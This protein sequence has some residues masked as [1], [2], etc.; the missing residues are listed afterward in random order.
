MMKSIQT[1]FIGAGA[2]A[3]CLAH[4]AATPFLFIAKS[5]STTCCTETPVWWKAID[6]IFILI[7]FAAIK[8][9]TESSTP[10]LIKL[11]LW[12]S[13]TALA[14]I[15]LN[16]HAELLYTNEYIIYIPSLLLVALHFYNLKF[17]Q[18]KENTCCSM[19]KS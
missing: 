9:S 12:V 16:E 2:S 11:S 15:I 3:L 14:L 1:D 10:K 18:C 8:K 13:W 7:S 17:C 4:C 5:C 19:A 6:A